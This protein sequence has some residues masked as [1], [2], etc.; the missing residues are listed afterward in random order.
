MIRVE[1]AGAVPADLDMTRPSRAA[2]ELES[3]RAFIADATKTGSPGFAAYSTAS[4][5]TALDGLFF[6]KCAY[7]ESFYAKTQPVDVEHYRPK[8]SVDGVAAH[9]GY[10][11]LAMAWDN[12]LPSCIDCNRRRRQVTPDVASP[13]ML[14]LL[15]NGDFNRGRSINTGK[16]AAFPLAPGS[17]R[18]MGEGDDPTLEQRLLL[19]PTRDDPARHLGFWIDRDNPVALAY[20]R[21]IDGS[22]APVLP[23][24]GEDLDALAQSAGRV[25]VSAM[26]AVSIQVYG[27]NRLPLVQA[28]TQLLRDLEFLFEMM[29]SVEEAQQALTDR[30]STRQAARPRSRG[31]RRIDIDEE[32]AFLDTM[33]QRLQGYG[34]MLRARMQAMCDARA[35]YSALA[36]EWVGRVVSEPPTP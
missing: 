30:R 13:S 9:R 11:W 16:Q 31:Q 15:E 27:L 3:A 26:G 6:G 17:F 7:C 14:R 12:L 10:W 35:P 2:K 5:K 21:A 34:N 28:R 19:D 22:R 29:V 18:A 33:G 32:I 25:G 4:V 1:R 24:P 8:G 36:R 23:D 20:P